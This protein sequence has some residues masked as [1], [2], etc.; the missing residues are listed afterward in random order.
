M[1][2]QS[3]QLKKTMPRKAPAVSVCIP[4]FNRAAMLKD[5]ITSVL[6]QTWQD[7]ELIVC[8]NASEDETEKVV[9]SFGDRRIAYHRSPRNIGQRPNWNRCLDL[10]GGRYISVFFDDDMMMPDNLAEKVAVLEKNPNVGLVHSKYHI[11]DP[12]GAM[13]DPNTNKTAAGILEKGSLNPGR[14][15]LAAL[16]RHNIIH[17]ST[18]MFRAECFKKLGGFTDRLSLAFDWE[19]WMRIASFYDVAFIAK[20]L[21]KWRDHT[22]SLTLETSRKIAQNSKAA[23]SRIRSDLAGFRW[24]VETYLPRISGDKRSGLKR[25]LWRQMGLRVAELSAALL[26]GGVP[27]SEVRRFLTE[28]CRTYPEILTEANVWKSVLKSMMSRKS[29]MAL[30]RVLPL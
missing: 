12:F 15:V 30:K 18:V 29:I 14:D 22:G 6:D 4:T 5:C 11:V 28:T 1:T 25:Q 27:K 10:A 21:V 26:E 17:E 3:A 19:F 2:S 8:D 20:P 24:I 16:L 7:F 13:L 23:V 9:A